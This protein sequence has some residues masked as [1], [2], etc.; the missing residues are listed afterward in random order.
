MIATGEK[1]RLDYGVLEYGFTAEWQNDVDP[2]VAAYFRVA[3][4]GWIPTWV[5]SEVFEWFASFPPEISDE[6]A[7]AMSADERVA[8]HYWKPHRIAPRLDGGFE[9]WVEQRDGEFMLEGRAFPKKKLV[10]APLEVVKVLEA[11][12]STRYDLWWFLYTVV[13]SNGMDFDPKFLG[14]DLREAGGVYALVAE[15]NLDMA[16]F[17]PRPYA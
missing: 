7:D 6:A 5:A 11:Q 13:R 8:A 4:G 9:W 1:S 14:S 12:G 15:H 2:T 17:V 10:S 3:R 16:D